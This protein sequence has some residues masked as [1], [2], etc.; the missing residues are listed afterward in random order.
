MTKRID[1]NLIPQISKLPSQQNRVSKLDQLKN[2]QKSEFK[3]L[4]EKH[5]DNKTDSELSFSKH[6][7]KRMEE[8]NLSLDSNEFIKLKQAVEKLQ[9]KGSK[10]SLVITS[11]AAY[12][13][14]VN[15]GKIITAIDKDKMSDN[16]FT[17]ID[18][19][20]FVN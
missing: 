16:V 14:D 12:I 18:S 20:V 9:Q 4:F 8:R 15:K 6:A 7:A 11:N 2:S 5:V 1:D 19:T 10:E 13:V 17:N 3:E